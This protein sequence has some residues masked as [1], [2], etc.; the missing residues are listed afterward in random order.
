MKIETNSL[1]NTQQSRN[2]LEGAVKKNTK[3]FDFCSAYIKKNTIDYFHEI[4]KKNLYKGG[5]RF[6]ARWLLNDLVQ[7]SSDIEAYEI[8]KTYG[9]DFYI[10]LDFHG[11]I[12]KVNPGQILMGSPNMT[13][14]G[15]GLKNHANDETGVILETNKSNEMYID[16]LFHNAIKMDDRLFVE[17]CSEYYHFLNT[18]EKN[19][20]PEW[21]Q[22]LKNK[23]SSSIF[24]SE[25]LVNECFFS[26]SPLALDDK[27]SY[28]VQHDI[29]LLSLNNSDIINLDQ[30]KESFLSSK[31]YLWLVHKLAKE[32]GELYFGR[33]TELLHNDLIDDPRPY[34]KDVK[35]LLS[36]LLN[37]ISD[38][39]IQ[40]I[41][42]ERPNYSQK[43]TLL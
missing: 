30:L 2:W 12:Y 21:S 5:G 24:S 6:L 36:N 8:L 20:N 19:P 34:R 16:N 27:D 33:I 13:N 25:I 14:S 15:F 32:N 28:E 42:I 4:F 1:I 43:I 37:W 23:V 7:G 29:S 18:K 10:K 35:D 38:L 39:N 31:L 3:S 11:K 40:N 9:Y 22:L 26:K 41:K 17:L